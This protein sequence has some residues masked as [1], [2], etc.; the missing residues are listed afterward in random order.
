M[1]S[2]EFA[3]W[4]AYYA[5]EPFGAERDN[6]HAG[7]VAAMVRNVNTIKGSPVRPA[8][9]MLRTDPPKNQTPQQ[10]KSSLRAYAAI[11]NAKQRVK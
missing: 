2:L 1:D 4:M 10:L 9:F 8:D 3:E 11:Q 6:F 7:I 5:A